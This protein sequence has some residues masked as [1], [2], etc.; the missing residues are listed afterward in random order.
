MTNG[1]RIKYGLAMYG[2]YRIYKS[3]VEW[4]RLTEKERK[5]RNYRERYAYVKKYVREIDR[6]SNIEKKLAFNIFDLTK[7][8]DRKTFEDTGNGIIISLT[9][10]KFFSI[11]NKFEKDVKKLKESER[12]RKEKEKKK[13]KLEEKKRIQTLIEKARETGKKQIVN[14]F[15]IPCRDP[16]EECNIDL[17]IEFIDGKGK[18]SKDIIHTW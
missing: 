1:K 12:I 7:Y 9:K 10:Q 18:K 4:D 6:N 17:V 13:K 2:S 3:F 14:Q 11:L 8:P 16:N 15:S 5:E